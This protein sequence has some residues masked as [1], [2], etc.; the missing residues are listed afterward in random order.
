MAVN[1]CMKIRRADTRGYIPKSWKDEDNYTSYR[2]FSCMSYQDPNYMGFGPLRTIND[3]TTQPGFI[4]TWHEHKNLDIINYM[5]KGQCRH[6]D[7]LGN[8]RVAGVG[9]IQHFWCGDGIWHHLTNDTE[10]ENRYLQIWIEPNGIVNE[11]EPFYEF[12]EKSTE[13]SPVPVVWKNNRVEVWGGILTQSLMTS[14]MSY[15]LVLEGTCHAN[16]ELLNT[17]DAVETFDPT[18]IAPGDGCHIILF[19]LKI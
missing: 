15:V 17:G 19:E 16:G 9:Q 18:L 1:T 6:V 11:R 3:D 7:N 12:L 13:F 5:I 14:G 8:D 4:T 10:E 2:S